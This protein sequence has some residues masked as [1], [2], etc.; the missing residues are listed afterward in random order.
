[1][2][3]GCSVR[4][5]WCIVGVCVLLFG[6]VP[7]RAVAPIFTEIPSF[8]GTPEPAA[9]L[10]RLAHKPPGVDRAERLR[11]L[12]NRHYRAIVILLQ[13]P[14]DPAIPG[15]P[16]FLADT[17]AHPPSAYDSLFFSLGAWPPRGSVR[18]YYREASA[19]QFDID[20]V[21]TRWH[22]APHPYSYY[23]DAQFGLGD[24]P[25]NAQ[26]MAHDAVVLADPD[27]D[28]RQFDNDGPDG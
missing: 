4:L 15:D 27:Y 26:Q 6:A 22:M 12:S 3:G 20:G 10:R 5:C 11:N 24:V 9:A 17:L 18:D 28:F 25:R 7:A 2:K 1:M 23:V 8:R 19:A 21:V 13:F 16:G 14:P